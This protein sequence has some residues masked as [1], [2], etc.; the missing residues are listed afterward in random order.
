M[1][2]NTLSVAHQY[3]PDILSSTFKRTEP[4]GDPQQTLTPPHVARDQLH[5]YI[6]NNV[7]PPLTS[8][9]QLPLPP[10]YPSSCEPWSCTGS[11]ALADQCTSAKSASAY[12][13]P[14]SVH[15]CVCVCICVYVCAYVCMCVYVELCVYTY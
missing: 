9:P 13:F 6:H 15:M 4:D 5:I 10:T 1:D 7:T 2:N 14:G 8:P 12:H 11:P 3:V